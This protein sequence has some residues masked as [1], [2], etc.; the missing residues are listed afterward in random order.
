MIY[1][2]KEIF[3]I[4]CGVLFFREL[5]DV[6]TSN[7]IGKGATITF[8]IAMAVLILFDRVSYTLKISLF[9]IAFFFGLS[10]FA[11]YYRN[12]MKIAAE[13]RKFQE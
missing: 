9:V 11:L 4:L 6:P 1:L 8:Y 3:Q 13:R 7:I 2:V 12:G 10:A 5:N